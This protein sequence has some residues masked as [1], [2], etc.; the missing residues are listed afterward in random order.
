M[1]E[2]NDRTAGIVAD[3]NT[4]KDWRL[5]GVNTLREQNKNFCETS[6]ETNF[7]W[8][9][10]SYLNTLGKLAFWLISNL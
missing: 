8:W 4:F 2:I 1:T 9:M 10:Y 6:E 5:L 3:E 7:R